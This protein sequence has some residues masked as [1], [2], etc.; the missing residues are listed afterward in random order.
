M[1]YSSQTIAAGLGAIAF[2]FVASSAIASHGKAG[3]WSVDMTIAGQNSLRMPPGDLE[4]MKAAGMMPNGA[5][6][7]TIRR[8]MT[9][10]EVADDSK[11]IDTS[12]L[13][14]CHETNRQMGTHSVSADLVCKGQIDGTGHVS[15][16]YDSDTHYSGEL[17][18]SGTA[19]DGTPLRQ[20][21]RFDGHW[22]SAACGDK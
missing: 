17:K 6:G 7:F 1:R 18:I 14:D 21:Q 22:V 19:S 4:R 8:C 9:A 12:A 5:G 13:K 3:L 11:M 2:V 20:D 10:A 16:D 15:V